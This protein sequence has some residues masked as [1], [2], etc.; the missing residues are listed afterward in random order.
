MTAKKMFV[1]YDYANDANYKNLLLAWA[2]NSDFA[3]S[4]NDRSV[5]VSVD[6]TDAAPIKRVISAG[7]HGA[8]YFLCLIGKETHKSKWVAWEIDK[9]IELKKRLVA[10]KIDKDDETPAGLLDQGASWTLS[11]TLDGIVQAID[12]A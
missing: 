10:I 2:K 6:S 1:S 12:A 5:D 3:F 7:I 4:M 11:F 9:A 8:T